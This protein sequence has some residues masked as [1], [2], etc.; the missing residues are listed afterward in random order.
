MVDVKK[1]PA[2][3]MVHELSKRL[4]EDKRIKEPD[5]TAFL[6]AG[7]HRENSW[8]QEDWYFVRLASTLR[9]LYINGAIG[10]SR[11]SAQYGDATDRGSKRYH[12]E[13]GS[14]FIIRDMFHTL[15]T[16]GLVKKTATGRVLSPEGQ[17]L[18]DQV[19]KEAIKKASE[20]D[21]RLEKYA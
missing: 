6:K 19:A 11:L 4:S 14:R 9:K 10:I 16:L 3:I 7:I 1:V 21:P 8:E 15:E 13:K 18:L 12:P 17:K 20:A 5:W 2:D